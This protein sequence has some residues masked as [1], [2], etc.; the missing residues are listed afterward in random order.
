EG[1]LT[2]TENTYVFNE[3]NL[4]QALSAMGYRTICIG[5]TGFFNQRT[6]LSRVLPGMFD[7]AHWRPETS[8]AD[9]Q[10]EINQ[11]NLACERLAAVSGLVFLFFLKPPQALMAQDRFKL[12]DLID[13]RK[14]PFL[15]GHSI[16]IFALYLVV[17][18]L[19]APFSVYAVEMVRITEHQLGL[20]YA[21]NGLMVVLLQIPVTRMLSKYRLTTQLALGAFVYAIGYGMVGTLV[22][23]EYFVLAIFV[24]TVGEIF[25]SPPS[26]AL[27]SRLAPDGRMGRY[28]G[29]FGFFVAS[30]WSFGPLYGGVIL[31][32]FG[33]NA[34]LAWAL[35]SSLA[36]ISGMGYLIFNKKL[37]ARFN[38]GEESN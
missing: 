38:V 12:S 19:I 23:F 27:T 6:A 14:D 20:L 33:T 32:Y 36:I 34:P 16:L 1:S 11:V 17:A 25:M 2:S 30:G 35:I 21:L 31:D 18:Q 13:I 4:P 5:G 8:V 24:V 28:M 22:G 26:L 10:S 7:E 15:A 3:A 29:I 37:P 9:H